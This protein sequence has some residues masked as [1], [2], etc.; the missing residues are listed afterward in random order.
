[1]PPMSLKLTV[2]TA[3]FQRQ[4]RDYVEG[5]RV[6]SKKAALLASKIY[7]RQL[8]GMTPPGDGAQSGTATLT[9]EDQRRGQNAIAGDLATLFIG[10][11]LKNK[12]EE[13]WPDVAGIHRAA[14][15]HV[16]GAGRNFG[17]GTQKKYVD[18]RKLNA[19]RRSLFANVGRLAANWMRAAGLV[20]VS[21]PA[22]VSRHGGGGG[23]GSLKI[24]ND[25]FR[26]E[27]VNP[28]VPPF[29]VDDMVRRE[30]DAQ[31]NTGNALQRSLEAI[32]QKRAAQFN[33]RAA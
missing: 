26:F 21:V 25:L 10:R 19:L 27:A 32:L 28:S 12:R 29:L 15:I 7:A 4:F 18:V 33:R 14:F 23:Q 31:R 11:R 2:E 30:I 9:K 13:Q 8:V 24:E 5:V 17:R 16:K 22:W 3:G 1:M 6:D 20:G